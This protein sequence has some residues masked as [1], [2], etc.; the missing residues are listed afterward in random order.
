MKVLVAAK[1]VTDPGVEPKIKTGVVSKTGVERV[2][3]SVDEASIQAAL[4]LKQKLTGV[5]VAV[6]SVGP[7][8]DRDALRHALAMGAD[9]VVQIRLAPDLIHAI[10]S[11][12]VAK[13]LRRLVILTECDMVLTGSRSS[14]GGSGQVGAALAG[15]LGWPHLSNVSALTE[16]KPDEVLASCRLGSWA[17]SGWLPLPCV[18]VCDIKVSGPK[19][20][21]ILDLIKAK[22]RRFRVKTFHQLNSNVGTHIVVKKCVPTPV[23]RQQRLFYG[24]LEASSELSKWLDSLRC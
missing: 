2:I 15:L 19:I 3:D 13:L 21:D 17:I 18:L 6:A 7:I 10:D 5:S 16:L 14:D 9:E 22:K 4:D 11:F 1:I 8:H 24:L 12:S 23:V 20:V